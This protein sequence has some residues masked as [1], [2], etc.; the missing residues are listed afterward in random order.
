[1]KIADH[2]RGMEKRMVPFFFRYLTN[3]GENGANV[4]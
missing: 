4:D 2:F 3:T 1:M